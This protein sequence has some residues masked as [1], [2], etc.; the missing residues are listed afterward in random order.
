MGVLEDPP[1]ILTKPEPAEESRGGKKVPDY[2][3]SRG[4]L[5]RRLKNTAPPSGAECGIGDAGVAETDSVVSKARPNVRFQVLGSPLQDP[6]I[7]EQGTTKKH[8]IEAELHPHSRPRGCSSAETAAIEGQTPKQRGAQRQEK[9]MEVSATARAPTLL[10][11]GARST[12]PHATSNISRLLFN[13][14]T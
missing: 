2:P 12:R 7:N 13:M 11:D 9:T 1:S 6:E 10:V 14:G 3:S 5:K 8:P 4:F